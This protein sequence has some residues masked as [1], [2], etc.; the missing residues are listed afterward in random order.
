MEGEVLTDTEVRRERAK[1]GI[2]N[3]KTRRPKPL[4]ELPLDE[5]SG[6]DRNLVPVV[7]EGLSYLDPKNESFEER[8]ERLRDARKSYAPMRAHQEMAA[9][10]LAAGGSFKLAAAQAGVSVRQV[11]K[12]YTDP[13][14]RARIEEQRA[15]VF[16][17]IRGRLVKEL[18][19]RTR[20]GSIERIELLDLLRV[21][22]RM[23]GTPG[24]KGVTNIGEVNVVQQ[25]ADTII[26]ALLAPQRPGE[27]PD[28]PDYRPSDFSVPGGDSPE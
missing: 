4:S 11:K 14:F 12:Y 15:T 28:F 9:M 3:K 21:F 7:Q 23:M 18:E 25:N 6:H 27:S 5:L 19:R 1:K 20:P 16:S 24:G 2:Q 17:K 26:A 8:T 13:D 10:V 22:D